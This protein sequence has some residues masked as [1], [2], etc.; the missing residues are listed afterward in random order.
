MP[1]ICNL[2]IADGDFH[3]VILIESLLHT[4]GKPH[5]CHQT[6]SGSLTLQ[7]LQKQPP[8][9][10]APRPDLILLDLYL[11]GGTGCEVLRAIKSRPELRSIPVIIVCAGQN[12]VDVNACYDQH[13]NAVVNRA[14]DLDGAVRVVSAIEQFWLQLAELPRTAA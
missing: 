1:H 12:E 5:Q 2:L 7:F 6:S 9:Q 10:D 13:A 3:Q 4:L 14:A 11:S 8:Y